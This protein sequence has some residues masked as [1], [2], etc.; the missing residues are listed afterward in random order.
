MARNE[1]DDTSAFANNQL[2]PSPTDDNIHQY[3]MPLLARAAHHARLGRTL[4]YDLYMPS[5]SKSSNG[6]DKKVV[7]S[8][9]EVLAMSTHLHKFFIEQKKKQ[10]YEDAAATLPPQR[11]AFLCNP[12]PQYIATQ[13]AAWSSGS[14][15]VPL[16]VSH[17]SSELAYV[18]QDC[19]A[20][21]V[22]D[23]TNTLS[24]GREL[25]MAA[26]E[27]GVMDR[28]WC[29]DDMLSGFQQVDDQPEEGD[30]AAGGS[31]HEQYPYALGTN[32]DI[33]SRDHPALIIY[34]SG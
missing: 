9:H 26:R 33:P 28:Y 23:G 34:T 31:E 2:F 14:I 32:G 24:E 29:L 17:K 25:R 7:Y 4:A 12:G 6:D 1:E 8:Y 15:A 16:C 19:D 13:F 30:E 18:L 21:F 10:Q 3:G 27:A 11:I 5:D 22:V 20:S